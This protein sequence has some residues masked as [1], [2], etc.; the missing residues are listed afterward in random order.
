MCNVIFSVKKIVYLQ[1]IKNSVHNQGSRSSLKP[2]SVFMCLWNLPLRN[3]VFWN[4]KKLKFCFCRGS[5]KLTLT[6]S[7]ACMTSYGKTSTNLSSWC[8]FGVELSEEYLSC[9]RICYPKIIWK[10][11]YLYISKNKVKESSFDGDLVIV[12]LCSGPSMMCLISNCITFSL[13][14][15][16]A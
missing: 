5:Q 3:Q 2:A 4:P 8:G 11:E 10:H 9:R 7:P 15:T 13:V 16:V 6:L 1:L 12:I 14:L